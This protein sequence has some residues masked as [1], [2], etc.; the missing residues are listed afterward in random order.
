MSQPYPGNVHCY[1]T[2]RTYAGQDPYSVV[3]PVKKL[4]RVTVNDTGGNDA[5]VCIAVPTFAK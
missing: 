5:C 1:E 3:A 2:S 4:R